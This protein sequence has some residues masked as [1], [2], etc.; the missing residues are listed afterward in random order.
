ME[1]SSRKRTRNS[2]SL[3]N[4]SDDAAENHNKATPRAKTAKKSAKDIKIDEFKEFSA[5]AAKQLKAHCGAGRLDKAI[6]MLEKHGYTQ[7]CISESLGA[8][9]SANIELLLDCAQNAARMGH[10]EEQA[11]VI[12]LLLDLGLHPD[13]TF[14]HWVTKGCCLPTLKRCTAICKEHDLRR[15]PVT[16]E[17]DDGGWSLVSSVAPFALESQLAEN[18][19]HLMEECDAQLPIFLPSMKGFLSVFQQ[20]SCVYPNV[21]SDDKDSGELLKR[22]RNAVW[23]AWSTAGCIDEAVIECRRLQQIAEDSRP[24]EGARH[25][26]AIQLLLSMGDTGVAT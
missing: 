6:A 22:V 2:A 10:R 19:L 16:C 11:A 1:I 13:F 21:N 15:S 25:E 23:K 4:A 5:N 26:A 12:D 8:K 24:G 17:G 7:G 14:M 18:F 20:D 3:T 9:D